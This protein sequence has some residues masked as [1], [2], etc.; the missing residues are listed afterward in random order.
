MHLYRWSR[1]ECGHG[2]GAG[3]EDVL[4][5]HAMEISWKEAHLASGP[6]RDSL[7]EMSFELC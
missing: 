7:E 5:W 1:V 4:G 3:D 6:W 2:S